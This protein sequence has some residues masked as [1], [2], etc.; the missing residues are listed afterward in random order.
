[1]TRY[2]SPAFLWSWWLAGLLYI[3]AAN[4]SAANIQVFT[5]HDHPVEA[6]AGIR[7]I[8]L[9]APTSLEVGLSFRLPSDPTRAAAIARARLNAGG[10][11]LQRR[12]AVA[13][14][15]VVYAWGL[16]VEKVPAVVMDRR[17]V[18]YGVSDVALAVSMIDRY[19]RRHL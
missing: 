6:A 1:M 11:S 12:L 5:D 15:G 10:A 16:G 7:V 4:A 18:V 19:R 14:Q 13:Y 9:D 8:E 2:R 17:Y 3:L